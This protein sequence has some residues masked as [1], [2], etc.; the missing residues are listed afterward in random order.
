MDED[1]EEDEEGDEDGEEETKDFENNSLDG[2][3]SRGARPSRGGYRHSLLEESSN[4][5]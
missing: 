4:D 3:N 5:F 1:D 2:Q